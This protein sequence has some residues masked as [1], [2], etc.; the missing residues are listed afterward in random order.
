[1]YP[2][3]LHAYTDEGC[4]H[5]YELLPGIR[6][7][8]AGGLRFSNVFRPNLSGPT[9]GDVTQ[10]PRDMVDMVF[11]PVV[12]EYI[13]NYKLQIFNRS[14]VLIFESNDIN[15]GW[16]GYYKGQLCM[17]GVYVWYVE[18]NYASGK[19]YRKVGDITLLH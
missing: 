15:I 16:D 4:Y 5:S 11:Y 8:P 10:L 13:D 1:M 18:G 14:G 6:V 9:G 17:Q 2:V 7:I 3:T 19:P 12:K